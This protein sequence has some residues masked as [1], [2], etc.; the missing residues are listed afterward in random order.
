MISSDL[1]L[2][3]YRQVY[4]VVHTPDTDNVDRLRRL[5]ALLAELLNE[6][7]SE[8]P[9]LF[10]DQYA[11]MMFAFDKYQAPRSLQHEL[12]ALRA[13]HLRTAVKDSQVDNQQLL[14]ALR[15][16]C[17]AVYHFS[18]RPTP[19]EL[20]DDYAAVPPLE[21]RPRKVRARETIPFLRCTVLE[22][23]PMQTL[24]NGSKRC[25]MTCRTEEYGVIK[26]SLWDRWSSL[27]GLAWPYATLHLFAIQRIADDGELFTSL[28]S[29]LIVLEPDF[30]VDAT[31]I[32]ECFLN[33]GNNPL[34]AL[35]RKFTSVHS[36][37]SMALGN[38]V[39]FL[40]DELVAGSE[41]DFESLFKEALLQRPLP[42]LPLLAANPL[43]VDNLK[44]QAAEHFARLQEAIKQFPPANA[45]IEPSFMSA[46][47]GLQGRLDLLL[48]YEGNP[49][50]KE[51][52][53]LKSG[54][55]SS[56]DGIIWRNHLAQVTCY[57]LLLDSCFPQRGGSSNILYSAAESGWLRN[58]PN[59]IPLKQE[60]LVLRNQ[61][62]ALERL[63]TNRKFKVLQRLA[64]GEFGAA[65]PYRMPA[66]Q[67]FHRCYSTVS[68]LEKKY[69]MIMTSFIAREHWSGRVGNDGAQR[70]TGLASLWRRSISDK[71]SSFDILTYL[72][73]SRAESDFDSYHLRFFF[74]ERTAPLSNFRRGDIVLLYAL[75]ED[76]SARP[77]HHQ[78]LKGSIKDINDTSIT[79]S[80]RN[81]ML[82]ATDFGED[83]NWVIEHDFLPTQF[84]LMYESLNDFL[85][86]PRRL[87]EL[88]LGLRPPAFDEVG[89]LRYDDLSEEQ[90]QVLAHALSAQD[91]F[92]LQ[93][94]PGTG[95]TSRMLK[96]LVRHLS[97]SCGE[98]IAVLAF[99]NRAVDEICDALKSIAP[100]FPFLRLGSKDT[101]SHTDRLLYTQCRNRSLSE[102]AALLRETGIIVSTVS[103]LLS[104]KDILRLKSFDSVIIDE[105]SQLLEPQL[106]G[107]L[108][109]FRRFFLIGDEKQL[110]AVVTQQESGMA[111]R[112]ADLDGIDL[113]DLRNSLFERLLRRAQ[114]EGWERAHGIVT[115]QGRMHRAV[116]HFANREFY[117]AQLRP[118][119]AWQDEAP[120]YPEYSEYPEADV[121]TQSLL[122]ARMI[123]I[124]S[125]VEN[126]NK[127]HRGEAHC[128]AMLS[129][130]LAAIFGRRFGN[131]SLGVITPF[132]AQIAT[133]AAA[134][135]EE[136]RHNIS[137]DTVER[138]QGSER[139][140]IIISMAINHA[141]QMPAVQSLNISQN[142]DRKLNVALTRAR[143][144]VILLG[145]PGIL[146]SSPIYARL[147]DHIESD[148]LVVDPATLRP[149]EN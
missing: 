91:Y 106:V 19:R 84:K 71:E 45:S 39:N 94:P 92:L 65:P 111:V 28:S 126:N 46:R 74:S 37:A 140:V 68:R 18:K 132:R 41:R 130:R 85:A 93:G 69:F 89:P 2:F 139:D 30:L 121:L 99:T 26:V 81:K 47:Y 59:V 117:A 129:S 146:R 145:P 72:R 14:G 82:A 9:Q 36:S 27:G 50:R 23:A 127:I 11:R 17:L 118:I 75:E 35:L 136:L 10:S 48:E 134:L 101:T 3:F 133:V 58:A 67:E 83:K 62:V 61:L 107:L 128:V 13:L 43:F 5:A 137:I 100:D 51:V 16:F 114:S 79:I 102:I 108:T 148:G 4:G 115:A 119:A 124:P 142:V 6:V 56:A 135:P 112:D 24:A 49:L 44:A 29:T 95:K 66:V 73:L 7:T 32:A 33:A 103:S 104:N 138:F 144:Q 22:F 70:Q 34:L 38:V 55:H 31:E 149:T 86:A 15:A 96:G 20:Q 21:Y 125:V 52:I 54:R 141:S 12:H 88:L 78:I 53:E 1:A 110:P 120:I 109:R 60:V 147:L 80:L 87:R 131:D 8:E 77:L 123:F 63:L 98:H 76:G 105:A 25:V 40:F 113:D 90:N 97:E 122:R 116:Q 143:R 42:L 64:P 57:N